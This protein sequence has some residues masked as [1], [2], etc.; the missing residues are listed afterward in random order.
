MR[1][2]QKVSGLCQKKKGGGG[3]VAEVNIGYQT[4]FQNI[5]PSVS[6]SVWETK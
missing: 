6:F 4:L 1:A 5:V 2:F 3:I